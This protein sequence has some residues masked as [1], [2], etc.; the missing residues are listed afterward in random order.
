MGT[1]LENKRC[2]LFPKGDEFLHM[3]MT[4]TNSNIIISSQFSEIPRAWGWQYEGMKLR[5][6]VHPQKWKRGHQI[7]ARSCSVTRLARKGP[8]SASETLWACFLVAALLVLIA[9]AANCVRGRKI[10]VDCHAWFSLRFCVVVPFPSYT[11][12]SLE[13]SSAD[14]PTA[15]EIK[16]AVLSVALFTYNFS[17]FGS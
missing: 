9:H 10:E 5:L 4:L 8:V 13:P 2:A 12:V 17:V 7:T 14:R 11:P 16:N 15:V 3:C 6:L 1:Y